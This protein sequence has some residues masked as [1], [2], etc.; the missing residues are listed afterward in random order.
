MELFVDLNGQ[1]DNAGT[2]E[3]PLQS[4][5]CAIVRCRQA[6]PSEARTIQLRGGVHR[7]DKS[8]VV[9]PEDTKMGPLTIRSYKQEKATISGG[10]Q[11]QCTW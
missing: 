10:R 4:L 11:L 1:D 8:V 3:Q 7:L 9:T 5:A 2:L 6:A